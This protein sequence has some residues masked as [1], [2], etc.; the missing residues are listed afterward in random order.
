[1]RSRSRAQV[2]DALAHA[3]R[4]GIVH[5]DVKPSNILLED[6]D[7]IAARLLDFGLAQFD[8]ADTL[9]AVGD[10]PGTLAYIAPERLAGEEATPE[11]DVWSVGVLLWESLAAKHP[12][13]G[14]PL[15]EV[16]RAIEAGAPALVTER[17]DL[18]RRL[19][20]AVDGA[21]ARSPGARPRASA[22]ASDLRSAHRQAPAR[23]PRTRARR[24]AQAKAP[25]ARF[26]LERVAPIALAVAAAAVGA[27]VLPFWP[28]VLVAA[29]ALGAGLAAFVDPRL[30]LAVALATPVFP[31]GN[32]SQSAAL[33]YGAFAIAWLVFSWRDAR[34][35]LLFVSGPVL[36]G[37]GLLAL[38]PL[39]VQPARGAVRRAVQA[40]A[41]VLVA[42][43]AAG[44]SDEALLT[45]ASR[46]SRF[47]SRPSTLCPRSARRSQVLS[48]CHRS[49]WSVPRL[50]R[51]RPRSSRPP[52]GG[53]D[54][55]SSRSEPRCSWASSRRAQA[56]SRSCSWRSSGA[57]Q[58]RSRREGAGRL[59]AGGE[60]PMSVFR[61]I[62][63]K[64]E[65]LFEGVFGRAFRTH[66]QPI[67]L[68]RKLAKEMD[69]HRTVS[70]SRVYVPNEYTIYL[71]PADRQ[72]FAGYEESLVGELEEYLA[73]HARRERYALLTAPDVL[74]TT[75][76]DLAVGEF[77]IA[78]R[79]VAPDGGEPELT[80]APPELPVG[81]PGQT[82]I[83]RAP[84]PVDDAPPPPA[85]PEVVTLTVDGRKQEVTEPRLVLGRS[86]ACDVYVADVNV[87]RR[88]AELQQEGATYWIVDLGSTN[89]TAVNGKRIERERL[90]DGDR[91]TLGSTEI[92]FG[93]SVP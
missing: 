3:H 57:L 33:L 43:L 49:S 9:T 90:R 16:A 92:V 46:R 51:P 15:Q 8:G 58:E 84:A 71:S 87:S 44:L 21:L 37:V 79:L 41:A 28:G 31:I 32:A 77:G 66:V 10:V 85:E 45:A 65:G 75:D 25:Q 53:R 80:E 69:D 7:E 72:Q 74:V 40:V 70:V 91:I 36:A 67:E 48:S 78:T 4:T 18:P 73:E 13:W 12:F 24:P 56:S 86:R 20:A 30:G 42:A 19:V 68:A 23:K 26:P 22:L 29:L 1:M 14:V 60:P 82:M 47:G 63:S 54:S 27:T 88:H 55:A 11:S 83:Y 5:R 59:S 81:E 61:T 39:V 62:E 38:V 89:G 35:G 50:Q 52:A 17:P 93:R 76:A 34:S 2:L 64:I 6:R